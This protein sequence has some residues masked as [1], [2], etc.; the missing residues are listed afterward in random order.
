LVVGLVL[1]GASLAGWITEIRNERKHHW[2]TL[3]WT[4]ETPEAI[5]P[6]PLFREAVDCSRRLLRCRRRN[7]LVG[8][9]I[10]PLFRK[11]PEDWVMSA[12]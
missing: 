2:T 6:S 7:P 4:F 1:F 11:P 8:S 10:A 3:C 9:S 5:Q 12:K